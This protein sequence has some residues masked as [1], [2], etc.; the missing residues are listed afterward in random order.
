M[1]EL[2]EVQTVVS[3]LRKKII[4]KEIISVRVN[5]PKLIKNVSV[6]KFVDAICGTK[7]I[8]INRIG[9]NIIFD[10]NNGYSLISHLR[11]EGK[12]FFNFHHEDSVQKAHV[13]FNFVD[14]QLF[15]YDSRQFGTFY[16]YRSSDVASCKE[17]KK[18]GMDPLD[19]RFS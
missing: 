19:K 4:D 5:L 7:I 12:Y 16:L 9:K 6:S 13:I 10:F 2:P 15:Y 11:M 8:K 3:E 17:I 1:P 14:A 18:I